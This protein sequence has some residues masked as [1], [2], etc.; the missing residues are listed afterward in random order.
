MIGRIPGQMLS[1]S[2]VRRALELHSRH[3]RICE[4]S[5][6]E[7]WRHIASQAITA[8]QMSVLAWLVLLL[9]LK[10]DVYL[11]VGRKSHVD[12]LDYHLPI[13]QGDYLVHLSLLQGLA[14]VVRL[15]IVLEANVRTAEVVRDN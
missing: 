5:V 1:F 12:P 9:L 7:H 11:V 2:I 8:L 10:V 15:I 3:W 6:R 14:E 4:V 13:L